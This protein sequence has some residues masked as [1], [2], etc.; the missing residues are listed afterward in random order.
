[1]SC[2][3]HFTFLTPSCRSVALVLFPTNHTFSYQILFPHWQLFVQYECLGCSTLWSKF[4]W[5]IHYW[6]Y[7]KWVKSEMKSGSYLWSHLADVADLSFW[8]ETGSLKNL[9][10]RQPFLFLVKYYCGD[11]PLPSA[12]YD[13][14]MRCR[15]MRASGNG[16]RDLRDVRQWRWPLH[17]ISI[18]F[19]CL[20][21]CYFQN[22]VIDICKSVGM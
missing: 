13:R 19:I 12:G 21:L 22:R 15:T 1:M 17:Y 11:F 14:P 5:L 10:I 16:L 7:C 9:Y 8:S 20:V 6:M 4:Q 18:P 3:L 2:S